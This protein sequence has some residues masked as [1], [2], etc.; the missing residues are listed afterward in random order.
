MA[1]VFER[2]I[3]EKSDE[4]LPKF[5][6]NMSKSIEQLKTG[7]ALLKFKVNYLSVEDENKIP[8]PKSKKMGVTNFLRKEFY[9]KR[10][11]NKIHIQTKAPGQTY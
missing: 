8:N 3:E 1:E 10:K 7:E 6:K 5:K 2:Q 4:L 11:Q 9:G